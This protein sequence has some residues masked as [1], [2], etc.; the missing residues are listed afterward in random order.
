MNINYPY[1][2]EYIRGLLPERKGQLSAMETEAAAEES[3]VPIA[4]PETAQFLR[5]LINITG[6]KKILEIG[7][8]MGYSAIVMASCRDDIEITTIE[9]YDKVAARARVNVQNAD[10]ADRITILEGD[11]ADILPTLEGEYDMVFL[12]AAKGQYLAFLPIL[13]GLLKK[14]GLLVSD[15]VLYKG[16]TASRELLV[17]RKITIVKRLRMFLKALYDDNTLE[18][19]V[20]PLGDGVALSYI[21]GE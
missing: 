7:T 12:D 20:L 13:K 11:A 8:G 14:G 17:R 5:V 10:L 16:M 1:I 19:S 2:T 6:A 3:Y 21:K 4:E 9:R 18:T 15:N